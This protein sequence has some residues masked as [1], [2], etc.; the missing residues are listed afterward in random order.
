MNSKR[1]VSIVKEI[2]KVG[3]NAVEEIKFNMTNIE[4]NYETRQSWQYQQNISDIK[5]VDIIMIS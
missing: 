1:V 2:I 5:N 3:E 4:R